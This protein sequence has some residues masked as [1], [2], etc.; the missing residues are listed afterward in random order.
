MTCS[1]PTNR[2]F[3]DTARAFRL[4]FQDILPKDENTGGG[5]RHPMAR[6]TNSAAPRPQHPLSRRSLVRPHR[7]PTRL[8]V[9]RPRACA[10]PDPGKAR[11]RR[12]DEARRGDEHDRGCACPAGL[13]HLRQPAIGSAR[14]ACGF[15][16]PRRP[17]AQSRACEYRGPIR[18]QRCRRLHAGQPIA[19]RSDLFLHHGNID[20]LWD[21][22]TRKQ[23]ARGLSTL[24][25]G[26]PGQ[27]GSP[28]RENSDS[29]CGRP[30]RSCSSSTPE[31]SG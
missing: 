12:P 2:A 28:P 17:V 1:R 15:R 21:V 29:S 8:D 10:R 25:D 18:R 13:P 4:Q 6:R 7:R 16:H 27:P 11:S 20:R 24:P 30:S 22:W 3:I 31:G 19:D 14:H 5:L 26:Y 9:L 23:L